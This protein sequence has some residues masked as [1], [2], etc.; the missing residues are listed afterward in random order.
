MTSTR[1]KTDSR[2]APTPPSNNYS[3]GRLYF[4]LLAIQTVGAAVIYLIG[5][6]L[7]RRLMADPGA[8][9]GKALLLWSVL[10]I[11]LMRVAYWLRYRLVSE[12]PRVVP[13]RPLGQAVMFLGHLVFDVA[14]IF[15][16]FMFIAYPPEFQRPLLNYAAAIAGIFALFCYSQELEQLGRAFIPPNQGG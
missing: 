8:Q 11:V 15:F 3:A 4:L 14:V 6:P 9:G 10:A 7:Y 5:I 13:S 16:T 12:L 2:G 1:G